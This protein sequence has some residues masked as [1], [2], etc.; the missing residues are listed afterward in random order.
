MKFNANACINRIFLSLYKM[1]QTSRIWLFKWS[2]LRNLLNN[3]S[4]FG[5]TSTSVITAKQIQ[6]KPYCDENKREAANMPLPWA[7]VARNEKLSSLFQR[8]TSRPSVYGN[9]YFCLSDRGNS[10]LFVFR[11]EWERGLKREKKKK[12]RETAISSVLME[13]GENCAHQF[14]S[15]Q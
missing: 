4:A 5:R 8:E 14:K 7:E 3:L 10:S 11:T 1:W 15:W 2:R 13:D 9:P 12:K 6:R